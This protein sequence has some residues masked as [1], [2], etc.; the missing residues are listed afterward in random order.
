MKQRYKFLKEYDR[1]YLCESA[2]GYKVC[3]SKFGHRVTD[4]GYVI[5]ITRI[6]KEEYDE[7]QIN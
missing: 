2:T 5:K 7:K 3:F 1:Y 4:D 6:K